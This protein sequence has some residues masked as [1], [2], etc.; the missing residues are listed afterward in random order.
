MAIFHGGIGTIGSSL[1]AGIPMVIV[2]IVADQPFNGKL[3][4]ENRTGV[5]IPFKNLTFEKLLGSITKIDSTEFKRNAKSIGEKMH[6][7]NGVNESLIIIEN[8]LK[9]NEI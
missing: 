5:H 6:L 3:I 1:K 2:S 4:E 8:Y 7:E 9:Q